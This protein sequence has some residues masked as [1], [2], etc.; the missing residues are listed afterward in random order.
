MKAG[1]TLEVPAPVSAKLSGSMAKLQA[2]YH[3]WDRTLE[4][5]II[6]A[7]VRLNSPARGSEGAL[8]FSCGVDS[9]FSLIKNS[10]D[11][12]L[13][14]NDVSILVSVHGPIS[15]LETGSATCLSECLSTLS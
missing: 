5:V 9:V 2:I 4:E 8:F 14:E 10:T 6:R 7:P 1:A 11:H 15:L 12:P 3:G 13:R